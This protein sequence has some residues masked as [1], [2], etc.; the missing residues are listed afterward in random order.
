[1][2]QKSIKVEESK[3]MILE[4]QN[5]DSS[6][7]V[8]GAIGVI[9]VSENYEF[10]DTIKIYDANQKL[11]TII[12]RTDEYQIIVLKCLN[13]TEL[14]YQVKLDNGDVGYIPVGSKKVKFQTWEDHILSVFSVGF[15]EKKNPLRKEPSF[16]AEILYYDQ[17]EFF[18]PN[19]IKGEWL[20]VKYGYEGNW[21]Y[22]W[23]KWKSGDNLIIELYYFA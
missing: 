20:Q 5:P 2:E 22:G 3:E 18:H 23:I 6:E 9:T 17:D 21:K 14:Y 13:K 16:D 11:L 4:L 1:M 12:I 8:E 19:Q 7:K 10:G 15:D